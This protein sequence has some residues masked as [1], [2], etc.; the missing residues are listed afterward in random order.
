MS[1]FH[2]KW[3]ERLNATDETDKGASVSSVSDIPMRVE[4]KNDLPP[5]RGMPFSDVVDITEPSHRAENPAKTLSNGTDET[6]ESPSSPTWSE[7]ERSRRCSCGSTVMAWTY[8]SRCP[9]CGAPMPERIAA[10]GSPLTEELAAL[11]KPEWFA[12][13]VPVHTLSADES[14]ALAFCGLPYQVQPTPKQ[15][16]PARTEGAA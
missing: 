10:T 5:S 2:S 8:V 15:A 14:R 9:V 6:D 1:A 7:G 13:P 4:A 3:L 11:I 16:T 12:E